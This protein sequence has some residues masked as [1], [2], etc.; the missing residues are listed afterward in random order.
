MLVLQLSNLLVVVARAVRQKVVRRVQVV[1]KAVAMRRKLLRKELNLRF[2]LLLEQAVREQRLAQVRQVV[3]PKSRR[4]AHPS[5]EQ[6]AET[7]RRRQQLMTKR[8]GRQQV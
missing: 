2:R 6:P 7:V 4:V 1:V 5:Q 3:L 8:L